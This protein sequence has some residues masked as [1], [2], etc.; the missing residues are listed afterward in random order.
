MDAASLLAL[1][2]GDDGPDE[3]DGGTVSTETMLAKYIATSC[4]WTHLR[5]FVKTGQL[6]AEGGLLRA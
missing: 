2:F 4:I 5:R 6:E 3:S 1:A